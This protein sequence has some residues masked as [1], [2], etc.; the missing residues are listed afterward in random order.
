MM[1]LKKLCYPGVF[2]LCSPGYTK[3][4]GRFIALD[5]VLGVFFSFFK[6]AV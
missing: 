1:L 6:V 4:K 2:E 3:R 5:A